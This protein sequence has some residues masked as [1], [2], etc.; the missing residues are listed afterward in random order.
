MQQLSQRGPRNSI[1][2]LTHTPMLAYWLPGY[3]RNSLGRHSRR[4]RQI[5]TVH[6]AV[7]AKKSSLGNNDTH[8]ESVLQ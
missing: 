7:M 4:N 2:T 8:S 6:V 3:H 5:M 1:C